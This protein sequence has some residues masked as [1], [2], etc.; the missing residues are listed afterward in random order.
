MI[1]TY[2]EFIPGEDAFSL[3][4]QFVV[5]HLGVEPCEIFPQVNISWCSFPGLVLSTILLRFHGLNFPVIKEDTIAQQTSWSSDLYNL[6]N[7]VKKH[8]VEKR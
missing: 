3:S 8:T 2:Q 4:H 7:A 6:D 5:F 1:W